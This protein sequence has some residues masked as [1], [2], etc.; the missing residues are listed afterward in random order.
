MV[1]GHRWRSVD[2]ALL[3]EHDAV[4]RTERG[5]A[6]GRGVVRGQGRVPDGDVRSELEGLRFFAALLEGC[7][8]DVDVRGDA[9]DPSAG[10]EREIRAI[11]VVQ[12]HFEP[13]G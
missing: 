8:G 3:D 7:R 9:T 2:F 5:L 13:S 6:L 10:V 12:A 4:V 1:V 11:A